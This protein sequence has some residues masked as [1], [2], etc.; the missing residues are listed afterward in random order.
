LRKE[1][2]METAAT[3]AL[4]DF[5]KFAE[6]RI[7]DK[8]NNTVCPLCLEKLSAKDF[9]ERVKQVEGREVHDQTVTELNLFH[10]EE[11]RPGRLSHHVN[12]VGWGH[13]HCNIVVKDL[14]IHQTLEWMRKVVDKNAGR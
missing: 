11:L 4:L 8:D 9:F 14:G 3:Q 2:Q 12:N 6:L 10:L 5:P 1:Q 7:V 13:Y